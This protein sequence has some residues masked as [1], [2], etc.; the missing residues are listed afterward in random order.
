MKAHLR[1]HIIAFAAGAALLGLTGCDL[2]TSPEERIARAEVYS[3]R[4]E[5]RAAMIELKSAL[6][7]RPGDAR[8]RLMLAEVSLELGDV[9]AADKDLRRA[10]ES[11]AAPKSAAP[12]AA[13]VMLA[14]GR[15]Q[16]LLE[17]IESG[18]L[19]LDE[20]AR[21]LN[22]G[23]ARLAT[24]DAEG[25]ESAFRAAIA[26]DPHALMAYVGVANA[27]AMRG[28]Y[29]SALA[30]MDGFLREHPEVAQ[31]WITRGAVLLRLGKYA[32]AAQAY[33]EALRRDSN[34]DAMSRLMA[35]SGRVETQL[36]RGELDDASDSITAMRK[37]ASG[38]VPGIELLDARVALARQ[39]YPAAVATLQRLVAAN[40][41]LVTARFLLGAALAAQGNLQQAEAHLAAV[42]AAAPENVEARK[43]LA[44]LRLRTRQPEAAIE[45]LRP[46]LDADSTDPQLEALLGAARMQMG[47]QEGAVA[48]LARRAARSP[49]E[50]A[51]QLDL[52]AA[53][54]AAGHAREALELLRSVPQAGG[55]VRRAV[56]LL[57]AAEVSEG[58]GAG[59]REANRIAAEHPADAPLLIVAGSYFT[60][61]RDFDRARELLRRAVA[62]GSDS[63]PALLA[64]SEVESAA[65]NIVAARD[66]L[67][68]AAAIKTARAAAYMRLAELDWRQGHA[69]EARKRL[70]DLCAL[71]P[72]AIEPRLTLARLY[73]LARDSKQAEALLAEI[74]ALGAGR[75]EVLAGIG[76]LQLDFGRYDQALISF[77]KAGELEPANPMHW[78]GLASAHLA[79]DQQEAA[80]QAVEKAVD[81]DPTS[82]PAA[83][84]SA[85]ID[86]RA[87]RNE[88]ALATAIALRRHKPA[89]A[90]AILLEG[91]VR[92][93]LGQAAQ[94][95]AAYDDAARLAPGLAI[96]A[97]QVK[98]RRL[99]KVPSAEAP[100]REWVRSHPK[101]RAAMAMLAETYRLA[102][103]RAEAIQEYE[104]LLAVDPQNPVVLNNLAWVCHE[105]GDAR[106]EQFARRAYAA[107]PSD[108]DIGDTLGWILVGN[109]RH[110]E[111]LPIL[112][113]AAKAAQDRPE[114]GY[115]F[116]VALEREGDKVRARS[117]L[118]R[119]LGTRAP[120]PAR[121]EAE[122]LRAL[123]GS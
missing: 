47:D 65:G 66:V 31:G 41:N 2:L 96:V 108:P 116:A 1:R 54:L 73:F 14:L 72:Q 59:R 98:A 32:D 102:G 6:K 39:D 42:V 80:R 24:G 57:R 52:A 63:G 97:R 117:E 70:E 68:Q 49:S 4:G 89:N 48:L 107:K 33:N 123:L 112:E 88:A 10:L 76:N 90:A 83:T 103:Q 62:S 25:A 5:Y 100:L 84:L 74:Q 61:Q 23:E 114:I 69:A 21:S 115:H 53:Q 56:L 92:L 113:T 99:A 43:Q 110:R 11:G 17:Q 79:L 45:A 44:Q 37:I 22:I 51:P 30:Q 71:E 81:A 8:A 46:V 93:R 104:R 34:L 121:G 64:L 40:P 29:E 13:R 36:A 18:K 87:G 15:E 35:L 106:A 75:A 60:A 28:D 67:G 95:L 85:L 94:A 77:R 82:V 120:F 78:L 111:A 91:D 27:L 12:L 38:Q 58:S 20:P 109:G 118:D 3:A 122:R 119:V 26:H 19:V 7:K 9:L 86:L 50:V 105:A 55:D 16:E 101:D